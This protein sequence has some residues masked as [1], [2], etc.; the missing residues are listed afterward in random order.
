MGSQT[1]LAITEAQKKQYQEQGFFILDKVIADEDLALLRA[2]SDALIQEQ[3]AEMDRLGTD[4]LN[5]SRRGSRYFSFMAFKEDPAL[6]RV[7]FNDLMAEV[8]RATIG[9]D[10]LLFWDQFV[11]KGT[12]N[13]EKSSFSWHQDSGYVDGPHKYYVNAWIPL[14]DV[15]E[16]NGTVYLLPYEKAGTKER[17]EHKVDPK[18]GDRVGYFGD[19]PGVP[20]VCSAGSIVVFSSVCFHRSGPNQTDKM[21]RAYAL[22]YAPEPV[23]EADGSIMG[24][25]VPFLKDGKRV[26]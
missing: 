21:R 9:D 19:E 2:K 7:I 4:A 22:Q 20:A 8:C 13:T 17:V 18:T 24:H 10:A 3:D 15:S 26:Q 25:V 5:L 16:E 11:V 1:V 14:D 23:H 6:G 12:S